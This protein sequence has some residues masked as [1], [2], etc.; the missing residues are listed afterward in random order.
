M[1]L[2]IATKLRQV[3]RV[4]L[5]SVAL[6]AVCLPLYAAQY[7]YVSDNLRVG[8][9]PEPVG[10]VPPVGVVLT[11][12]R[13]EILEEKEGYLKI[14][15]AEGVV[16]WIKD[17]YVTR[18]EPAVIRL[19]TLKIQHEKL[20]AE[21]KQNQESGAVL[22]KAN[23]SLNEQ[24]DTLKEERR[25]W[26]QERAAML[27]TQYSGGSWLWWL[28][29]ILLLAGAF[30]AGAFWYRTRVTKRLGGLRIM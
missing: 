5:G 13:L 18:E 15:T 10:N 4:I 30:A 28:L 23:A 17:I 24:L 25:E 27:A 6:L 3:S 1:D 16:G 14:K 11:G 20:Q 9:R 21:L 19:N 26:Q 12:M 2:S 8:V 29:W 7:V 22:E